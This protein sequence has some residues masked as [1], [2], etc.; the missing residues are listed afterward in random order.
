MYFYFLVEDLSGAELIKILM[1]KIASSTSDVYY[2]CKSFKGIGHLPKVNTKEEV[3]NAGSK[4]LLN[5][6]PQYLKGL[7]NSLQDFPSAIVVVLDNDNRDTE[8]FRTELEDVAVQCGITVDHVFCIAV[9]EIEAWLLGDEAAIF[10][11]YPKARLKVL[12]SYSQDSICGT[13][14]ILA[15]AV[16]PGGLAKLRKTGDNPG[17]LKSEWA[18]N[19]GKHMDL[20]NNKSRSFNQFLCEIQKRLPTA[21]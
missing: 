6:L 13:W 16:Y 21:S 18:K 19:I 11:A 10:A 3:K 9:E 5:R 2:D 4:M 15:D 17:M 12:R 20:Q 14:E 7:N 8:V 1:R